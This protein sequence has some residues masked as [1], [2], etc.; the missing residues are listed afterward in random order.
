M[1][2]RI[3]NSQSGT[4]SAK[5]DRKLSGQLLEQLN[6]TP[7]DSRYIDALKYLGHFGYL[8]M[9]KS[10]NFSLFNSFEESINKFQ[11][12]FGLSKTGELDENT[13]IA[14]KKPRCGVK[15]LPLI[16]GYVKEVDV[17]A[18]HGKE[19]QKRYSFI[20]SFFFQDI[21]EMFGS[22]MRPFE[23]PSSRW[24]S[25]DLTYRI[26]KYPLSS[27][28]SKKQVDLQIREAFDLWSAVTDLT[29]TE[30]NY[31]PV[32][33]DIRFESRGHGDGDSFDGPAGVLAH[34]YFPIYGGDVHF[35]A[36]EKWVTQSHL[37]G[38]HLMHVAA[39]EFGHALGLP[40][41]GDSSALM[42]PTIDDTRVYNVKLGAEDIEAIQRLYGLK[43]SKTSKPLT[44]LRPFF[45]TH[46]T[47]SKRKPGLWDRLLPSSGFGE[48]DN[49]NEAGVS[50]H[51]NHHICNGRELEAIVEI[52]GT[53][54]VATGDQVWEVGESGALVHEEPHN[55]K[56]VW[57]GLPRSPDAGFTWHNGLTYL[58]I[59]SKYY[60]YRNNTL[61]KG[62]P[63]RISQGFSGVPSYLDAAF[64]WPTDDNIYFIKSSKYWVFSPQISPPIS[65]PK[66]LPAE[67][68][69][70]VVA[71][72]TNMYNITYLFSKDLYWRMNSR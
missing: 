56:M 66:M 21:M 45:T 31:G 62:F 16:D 53:S 27:K 67:I 39:H 50:S 61:D 11:G 37:V 23:T 51:S 72:M 68:D 55:T 30:R 15:D 25:L 40:H 32:H 41:V 34:S 44:T 38:T 13:L 69:K 65:K 24:R 63:K 9:V 17:S 54:F 52:G 29:F 20:D 49:D 43:T 10:T 18:G 36:D 12:F 46:K 22:R 28:M 1:I 8:D 35:D 4:S 6:M 2:G 59:G 3:K 42:A 19:R 64:I 26:S 33:M 14:M 58:F 60:R 47:T 48:P 5:V 57:P 70:K 71:G 7:P